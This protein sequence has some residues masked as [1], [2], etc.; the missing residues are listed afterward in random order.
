M[1][2]VVK[3]NR[4]LCEQSTSYQVRRNFACLLHSIH[5]CLCRILTLIIILSH[6]ICKD[7]IVFLGDLSNVGEFK[8]TSLA[9]LE[10][11]CLGVK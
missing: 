9:V 8:G 6:Y 7:R 5:V 1:S 10:S 2:K 11:P 3:Q 4:I